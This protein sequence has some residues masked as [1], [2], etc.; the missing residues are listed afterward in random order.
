MER[1]NER[2]RRFTALLNRPIMVP[3]Q[4]ISVP[5]PPPPHP[6]NPTK[7]FEGAEFF[8]KERERERGPSKGREGME[9]RKGVFHIYI[10]DRGL[11]AKFAVQKKK[12]VVILFLLLFRWVVSAVKKKIY[13][14]LFSLGKKKS[15]PK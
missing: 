6:K 9:T 5:P 3:C 4:P 13:L 2:G 1:N 8:L 10:R 12:S 14:I 7:I 15:F 11:F